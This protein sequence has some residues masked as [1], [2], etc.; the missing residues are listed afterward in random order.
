MQDTP[1]KESS[2]RFFASHRIFD[3]SGNEYKYGTIH[4][5]EKKCM[6]IMSTPNF[7]EN[8][9][10]IFH[11]GI[12]FPS[13]S[14]NATL[15]FQKICENYRAVNFKNL[16]TEELQALKN[17]TE[18]P[19]QR[20]K[21]TALLKWMLTIAYPGTMKD[22]VNDFRAGP[23]IPG[24]NFMHSLWWIDR[25]DFQQHKPLITLEIRETIL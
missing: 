9:N 11:S 7:I 15:I 16:S 19:D 6:E 17:L 20:R 21:W 23:F 8:R 24:N 22:W 4:F 5:L 2:D 14:Q 12:L 10:T 1:I 25:Y 13:L 3:G 18:I